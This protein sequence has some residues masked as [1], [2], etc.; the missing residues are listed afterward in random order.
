[1]PR[2]Q[3]P[4]RFGFHGYV[5]LVYANLIPGA[6]RSRRGR[7]GNL[8]QA[9]NQAIEF[10]GRRLKFSRNCDVHVMK[11]GDHSLRTALEYRLQSGPVFSVRR[12]CDTKS[13]TEVATLTP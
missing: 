6:A 3:R 9:K 7:L 1:M 4:P 12:S 2:T 11:C 13:P 10:F 5:Q 8:R